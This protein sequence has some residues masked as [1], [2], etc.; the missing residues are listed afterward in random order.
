LPIIPKTVLR[1]QKNPL[2]LGIPIGIFRKK[3]LSK[4]L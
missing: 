4:Y 1:E 3:Y 2:R